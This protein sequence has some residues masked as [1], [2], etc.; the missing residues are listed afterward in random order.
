M[1]SLN[2]DILK[3][4]RGRIVNYF[5]LK[6]YINWEGQTQTD[7]IVSSKPVYPKYG[8]HATVSFSPRSLLEMPHFMLEHF[9][10]ITM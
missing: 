9:N 8:P 7:G 5:I 2:T 6:F 3:C 10:K 1:K 4:M